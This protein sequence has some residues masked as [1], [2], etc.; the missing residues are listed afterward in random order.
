MRERSRGIRSPRRAWC[1]EQATAH[2]AFHDPIARAEQAPGWSLRTNPYFVRFYRSD[3]R[4][5]ERDASKRASTPRRCR[6]TSASIAR[7]AFGLPIF[8]VLFC[9]PTM[10]LGVDIAQLN[11]VGLRNVPPTPANY[12][13]RSGRAGR[14]GQP[15]FVFTYCSA[16]IP[17]DQYFFKRPDRMVGGVVAPPRLDL[18]NEDLLRAHVHAVW[19]GVSDL[20]LKSSLKELLDVEGAAPTLSLL[21]DVASKLAD[22]ANRRQRAFD[23]ALVKAALAMLGAADPD[24][25]RDRGTGLMTGSTR[26][27][28][29]EPQSFE[30]RVRTLAQPLR[31]GRARAGATPEPG[32]P[33]RDPRM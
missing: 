24:G 15:A 2:D 27:R 20:D 3:I 29:V 5:P 14:S 7:N 22:V 32:H 18:A 23:L 19:L 4:R 6:A 17:H 11:V 8:P 9:S 25:S 12:A 33:R 30:A 1:G 13:Q 10:E 28:Q 26:A 16:G 31:S 21:P